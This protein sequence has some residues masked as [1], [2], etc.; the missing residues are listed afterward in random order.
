MGIVS[1]SGPVEREALDRDVAAIRS[2]GFHTRLAPHV[3]D[4]RGYLAG[5]D[6]DRAADLNAMFRDPGIDAVFCSRGGY[7]AAR[8]LDLLDYETIR[9]ERKVFVGFSDITA[10][11]IAIH[12]KARLVTFYGSI[13]QSTGVRA[14][15]DRYTDIGPGIRESTG[16]GGPTGG[17]DRVVAGDTAEHSTQYS[18]EHSVENSAQDDVEHSAGYNTAGLLR[19]VSSR[20]PLGLLSNPP[21]EEPPAGLFGGRSRGRLVGGCLSLIAASVGTPYDI[22]TSGAILAIEEVGER[23]Y[24]IDRM[25]GQLKSSGKL[26]RVAG[27][28]LGEFVGC[29][30]ERG[31]P[32]LTLDEI[33]DDYFAGL[34]VPVVSGLC[35]GHG[36]HRLT[37]PLGAMAEIDGDRGSLTIIEPATV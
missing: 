21:G 34:G 3:L 23:P 12:R 19:A 16:I 1:P 20:G 17:G 36:D 31:K 22:E 2:M 35:F 29:Q 32:T 10:L 28:V 37:L 15:I 7:G 26:G 30:A 4:R 24:R 9:S 18:V 33:F 8:I 27:I 5:S 11:H 14:G 13:H 6:A 25:L